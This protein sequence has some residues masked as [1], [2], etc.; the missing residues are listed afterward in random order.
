M[1]LFFSSFSV[2]HSSPQKR[3]TKIKLETSSSSLLSSHTKINDD[4]LNSKMNQR[5]KMKDSMM[6]LKIFKFCFSNRHANSDNCCCL[7]SCRLLHRSIITHSE[8]F[9]KIARIF[10]FFVSI[11]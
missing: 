7:V 5:E 9:E 3:R 11:H 2:S 10:T 6:L 8:A 1:T 4:G